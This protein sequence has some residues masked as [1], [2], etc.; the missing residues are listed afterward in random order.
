VDRRTII[1]ATFAALA[2]TLAKA[3]KRKRR[4]E[5]K[6]RA[7]TVRGDG[8]GISRSFN[9]VGGRYIATANFST[10]DSAGGLFF[11]DLH[12]PR[13]YMDFVFIENP[14][15]PGNYRYQEV[16]TTEATGKHFFAIDEADGSWEIQL[17]PK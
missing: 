8:S 13:G 3:R 9:L 16:V 10:S 1:I 6:P 12:G 11:V 5:R 14:E 17:K 15:G 4:K 2:P 7:V